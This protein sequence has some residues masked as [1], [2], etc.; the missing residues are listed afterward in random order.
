[1]TPDPTFPYDRL[2][3][4]LLASH[5]L[6]DF[7]H[8][9]L[10]LAMELLGACKPSE[11]LADMWEICPPMQHNSIFFAALF[12]QQLPREIR[13]LLTHE[14]HSDLRRLASHADQLIA[15]GGKQDTVAAVINT[16]QEETVAAIQHKGKQSRGKNTQKKQP[17]PLPP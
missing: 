3:E 11:L 7:Q 6:T 13:V 2:K 4:A 12:L 14:D 5:Q 17:P 15:F 16:P 9:E 8:V 10:L 1:M